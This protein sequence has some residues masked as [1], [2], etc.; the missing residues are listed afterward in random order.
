[1]STDYH[2]NHL[3]RKHEANTTNKPKINRKSHKIA[4]IKEKLKTK[5]NK[6]AKCDKEFYEYVYVCV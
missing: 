4:K 3:Y 6:Q 5:K 2:T 1:M